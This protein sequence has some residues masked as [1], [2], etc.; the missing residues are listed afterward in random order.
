MTLFGFVKQEKEKKPRMGLI[1]F[2]RI[3]EEDE[4]CVDQEEEA[5]GEDER[6]I[7]AVY[8]SEM[9]NGRE[10]GEEAIHRTPSFTGLPDFP[11][12]KGKERCLLFRIPEQHPYLRR[13]RFYTTRDILVHAPSY[14]S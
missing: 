6:Y 14:C 11:R 8:H 13:P 5:D 9:R 3:G 1:F 2:V 10:G 12:T 7:S 4:K